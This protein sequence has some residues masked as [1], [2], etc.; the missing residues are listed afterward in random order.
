MSTTYENIITSY[1]VR[2]AAQ[3]NAAHAQMAAAADQ[4]DRSHRWHE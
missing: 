1:D 3:F 4:A 2:G